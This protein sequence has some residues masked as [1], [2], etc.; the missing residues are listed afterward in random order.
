MMSQLSPL[1]S[2]L[3]ELSSSPGLRG[4]RLELLISCTELA[5]L[6][7]FSKTD[8]MCV[9]FVKQFGQWKEVA[10]TEAVR[11]QLNPKVMLAHWRTVPAGKAHGIHMNHAAY[12][13]FPCAL[14]ARIALYKAHYLVGVN[15][16]FKSFLAQVI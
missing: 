1:S 14:A 15:C 9:L 4:D 7:V 16:G 5:N 6:D 12:V 13:H 3:D 10:R 8:P 11:D 2:S